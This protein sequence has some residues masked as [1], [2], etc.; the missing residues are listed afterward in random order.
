MGNQRLLKW[1]HDQDSRTPIYYGKN[2]LEIFLPPEGPL[3]WDLECSSR[4]LA[5]AHRSKFLTKLS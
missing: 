5:I 2:S 3:P 4:G 1:S